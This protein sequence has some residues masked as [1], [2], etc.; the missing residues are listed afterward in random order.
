[1]RKRLDWRNRLGRK[2]FY[3]APPNP[4]GDQAMVVADIIEELILER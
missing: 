2:L 1:M 4:G 3:F